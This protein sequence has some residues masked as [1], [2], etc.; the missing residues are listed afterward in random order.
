MEKSFSYSKRKPTDPLYRLCG[1]GTCQ[2]NFINYATI[3]KNDKN[4]SL[5]TSFALQN[6][7]QYFD[8]SYSDFV[9]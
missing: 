4:K 5:E 2:L 3:K 9:K 6:L 8:H 7:F 1:F